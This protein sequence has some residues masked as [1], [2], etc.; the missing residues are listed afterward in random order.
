[1]GDVV[2]FKKTKAKDKH[3]GKS[4]CRSGFHK[5]EVVNTNPFDIKQGKMVSRYRCSRCGATKTEAR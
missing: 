4:L 5:W 3:K 2:A 1:M